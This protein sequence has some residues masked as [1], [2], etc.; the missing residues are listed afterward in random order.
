MLKFCR[1]KYVTMNE[2]T[3]EMKK[4]PSIILNRF[5][6]IEDRLISRKKKTGPITHFILKRPRCLLKIQF[7]SGYPIRISI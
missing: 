4:K 3:S 1:I 7:M 2:S 5:Y 6:K